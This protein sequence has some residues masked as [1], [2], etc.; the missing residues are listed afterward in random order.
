MSQTRPSPPFSP[1]MC[2]G[3]LSALGFNRDTD[4]GRPPVHPP[5]SIRV[6]PTDGRKGA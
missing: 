5:S 2:E 1:P 6:A 4:P 3:L